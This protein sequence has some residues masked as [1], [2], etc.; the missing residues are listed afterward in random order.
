[1]RVGI[2][3]AN[4]IRFSPYIFYYT[5]ILDRI[6]I[7]YELIYPDRTNVR[8]NF[9]ANFHEVAWKKSANVA[10]SYLDYIKKV[11]RI[12]ANEK[13]NLLVVLTMNNAVFM[14]NWLKKN[15]TNR[16][17]LDVRDY[18]HENIPIYFSYEKKA[19]RYSLLNIISSKKFIEFLPKGE[20][21]TCHNMKKVEKVFSPKLNKNKPITIAYIGTGSY[22]NNCAKICEKLCNDTRFRFV[23]HGLKNMPD[24]LKDFSTANNIEFHG[25]FDPSEKEEIIQNA[26]ILFNVYG[27]GSPLL[28]Y[29][30]SNKLYDSFVYGKPILTSP[31]T[32]MAEMA[33]PF[34][35]DLDFLT[36][37]FLD[38]LFEWYNNLSE[39]TLSSYANTKLKEFENE[40]DQ[41]ETKIIESVTSL[42]K[43]I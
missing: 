17:I 36:S 14:A 25:V 42:G 40:S 39:D 41:T 16:Y 7:D 4:N 9:T 35:F 13:Y 43:L 11:K 32:Y 21:Y 8:D 18:T 12:V 5:R 38:D 34:S 6:G 22:L 24:E 2:I 30:L 19:V 26:D 28:D 1:M 27:N 23:F 10:F 29:A 31:G 37:S 3:A 33:G 15:Y 20:Y